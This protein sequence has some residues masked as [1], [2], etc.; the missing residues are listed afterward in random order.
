M[1]IL[2]QGSGRRVKLTKGEV[3]RLRSCATLLHEL[4][5]QTQGGAPDNAHDALDEVLTHIDSKGEYKPPVEE[6]S[7]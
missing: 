5:I 1:Q 6:A 4:S 7:K 3:G 2:I